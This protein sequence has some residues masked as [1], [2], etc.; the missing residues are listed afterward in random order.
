MET[1]CVWFLIIVSVYYYLTEQWFGGEV[2]NQF[3]IFNVLI[4]WMIVTHCTHHTG[5]FTAVC[6]I[7]IFIILLNFVSSKNK[8]SLYTIFKNRNHFTFGE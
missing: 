4:L 1:I 2:V 6:V 3:R 5:Y 8:D 7:T